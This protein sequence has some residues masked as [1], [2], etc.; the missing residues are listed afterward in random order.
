MKFIDLF[1]LNKGLDPEDIKQKMVDCGLPGTQD[2][3]KE[4]TAGGSHT[5]ID[6]GG[7]DK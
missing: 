3:A 1:C 2:E 4:A 5:K 6:V 7:F